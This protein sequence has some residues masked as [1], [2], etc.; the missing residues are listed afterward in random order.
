MPEELSGDVLDLR[1]LPLDLGVGRQAVRIGHWPT[2]DQ[3]SEIGRRFSSGRPTVW[4]VLPQLGSVDTEETVGR[5]ID[6]DRV[7]VRDPGL[8][9]GAHRKR[10]ANQPAH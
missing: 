7:T 3:A 1:P 6:T 5:A 4:A 2:V 8:G 9:C 10:N